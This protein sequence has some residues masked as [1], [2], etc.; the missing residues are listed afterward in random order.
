[1]FI[2]HVHIR[3]KPEY[4][5]EFCEATETNAE[6]SLLEPG[7][8]RFDLLQ[9]QDDVTRFLLLEAYRTPE[10]AARHKETAHYQ[11]WRD[12]VAEMMAEPRSSMRYTNIY[13]SDGAWG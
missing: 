5:D 9:Q 6:A 4:L 12:I 7:I 3:V 11:A 2:V 8:V 13:P 10:D 1:M